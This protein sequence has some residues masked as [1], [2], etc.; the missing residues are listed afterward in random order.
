ML[1]LS[2][3]AMFEPVRGMTVTTL[4][5]MATNPRDEDV[6]ILGT[7]ASLVLWPVMNW[8]ARRDG[9][10]NG[11]LVWFALGSQS[12]C[13]ALVQFA[14]RKSSYTPVVIIKFVDQCF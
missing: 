5:A 10:A 14:Y 8:I 6:Y 4:V 1:N 13:S 12:C 11:V 7:S 9:N 3:T 2:P